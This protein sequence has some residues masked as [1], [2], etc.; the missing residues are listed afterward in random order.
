MSYTKINGDEYVP[1]NEE[2]VELYP[3][4]PGR[5]EDRPV[6][7]APPQ[8]EQEDD[9][10]QPSAPP[11]TDDDFNVNSVNSVNVNNVS[12]S[13]LNHGETLYDN[14]LA[15]PPQ[16]QHVS[17][18]VA[19]PVHA[20]PSPSPVPPPPPTESELHD[21]IYFSESQ[22]EMSRYITN[23]WAFLK[24]NF[25]IFILAQVVWGLII[26]LYFFLTFTILARFFPHS[27]P[28]HNNPN[29]DFDD[30]DFSENGNSL[31]PKGYLRAI[32]MTVSIVIFNSL[33]G[34]QMI[35]SWF[36]AV[37]N[38]MRTNSHILFRDFFSAFS[39][40]YYFRLA[41]LGFVLTILHTLFSMLYIIPGVWFSLITLFSIPLHG[42]HSFLRICKSIRFSA[43]IVHRHICSVLGFVLCLALL[44]LVGFFC[45][46]V[47]L[48]VTIP[49][50]HVSLCYAY[51]SLIGVNGVPMYASVPRVQQVVIAQPINTVN[52]V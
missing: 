36:I 18:P 30:S 46:L 40:K 9:Q 21:R 45:F 6:P 3:R 33:I 24:P 29:G 44:Q 17:I 11:Q 41:G 34:T 28:T 39:C 13:Q 14:D 42:E 19:I 49:L 16:Q 27:L 25:C 47:G 52:R 38:A 7:S 37:F 35:S 12:Y 31:G 4:L 50:A 26:L 48:L 10:P 1:N 23:G 43:K 51:H 20:L 22:F 8:T 32:L 15:A 5:N 2:P